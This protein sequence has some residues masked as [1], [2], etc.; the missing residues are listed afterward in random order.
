M[1]HRGQSTSLQDSFHGISR[2]LFFALWIG[3]LQPNN[4]RARI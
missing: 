1:E 3:R 2:L 4:L